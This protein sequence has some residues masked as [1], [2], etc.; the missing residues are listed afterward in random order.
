MLLVVLNGG[1]E[2]VDSGIEQAV[3]VAI[4]AGKP[5][6]AVVGDSTRV[7]SLFKQVFVKSELLQM[8][9]P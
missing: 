9:T 7:P 4:W 2:D 8:K 3:A 5:V 6:R 1:D